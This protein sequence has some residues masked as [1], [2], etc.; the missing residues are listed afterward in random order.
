MRSIRSFLLVVRRSLLLFACCQPLFADSVRVDDFL[1]SNHDPEWQHGAIQAAMNSAGE[2]G[3]VLFSPGA[4]YTVCQALRPLPGQQLVGNGAR[5]RRCDALRTELTQDVPVGATEMLVEHPEVFRVGMLVSPVRGAGALADGESFVRHIVQSIEGQR[6]VFSSGLTQPYSAGDRVVNEFS[7]FEMNE[8]GQDHVTIEGLIVD[9]NRDRNADYV[10]WTRNRAILSKGGLV[11]R[12]SVFENIPGEAVAAYGP[13]I[14]L[15]RNVF[16]NISGAAIHLSGTQPG[17]E[18]VIQNNLLSATNLESVRAVHAAGMITISLASDGIRLLNNIAADAD[19]PFV[20][21]YHKDMGDWMVA[22]NKVYGTQGLFFGRGNTQ[23]VDRPLHGIAWRDNYGEDV[24]LSELQAFAPQN[25]LGFEFIRNVITGGQVRLDG[26]LGGR[27]YGNRI[28]SS[29]SVAFQVENAEHSV[30]V[31][32]RAVVRPT[33]SNPSARATLIY[34][35]QS[36]RVTLRSSLLTGARIARFVI[37]NDG[38]SSPFDLSKLDLPFTEETDADV[39]P[40]VIGQAAPLGTRLAATYP[41]GNI[42]P[43]G[44]ETPE[45]LDG[46]LTLARYA[47][48]RGDFGPFRLVVVDEQ[49]RPWHHAELPADVNGDLIVAP[50]DALLLVNEISDRIW[51]DAGTGLRWPDLDSPFS[52]DVDNDQHISPLDALIAVN[53]LST[54]SETIVGRQ[55]TYPL[56]EPQFASFAVLL[57]LIRRV[58]LSQLSPWGESRAQFAERGSPR[59][60]RIR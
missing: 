37:A 36:G 54:Q 9:G 49:T 3:T 6:I 14:L 51:S 2:N 44:L 58:H 15:E 17:N 33:A 39:L 35:R 27:I 40:F 46:Y 13:G 52:F 48:E 42:F 56:P 10:A 8:M 41:L 57:L 30:V 55:G 47:D 21:M 43:A 20:S 1:S 5:I 12:N 26:V 60:Y 4:T 45:D 25:N 38:A 28:T 11:V 50:G 23:H 24:G 32:N 19:V 53:A 31:Q 18:V 59:R 29:T 22:G 16:R 7:M 34:D